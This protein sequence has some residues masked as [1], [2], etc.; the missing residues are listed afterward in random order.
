MREYFTIMV[1]ENDTSNLKLLTEKLNAGFYISNHIPAGRSTVI[2]MEK[3]TQN[4]N[5]LRNSAP[6]IE[7]ELIPA[8]AQVTYNGRY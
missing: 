8:E 1:K 2:T 5:I 4:R 3:Q 7:S 6:E